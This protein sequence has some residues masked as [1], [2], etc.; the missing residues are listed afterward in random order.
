MII[1]LQPP[2]AWKIPFSFCLLRSVTPRALFYSYCTEQNV[3]TATGRIAVF[4]AV[5][6]LPRTLLIRAFRTTHTQQ[7]MIEC[8][9]LL[10]T[11]SPIEKLISS[12]RLSVRCGVHAVRIPSTG[13][14]PEN[15][16]SLCMLRVI[17]PRLPTHFPLH[18]YLSCLVPSSSYIV[19]QDG[20]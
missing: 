20:T 10:S 9:I 1:V 3:G 5:C 12:C 18:L 16:F 19:V 13:V 17:C 7:R 8:E 11:D 14:R 4:H 15:D 6:L 2:I